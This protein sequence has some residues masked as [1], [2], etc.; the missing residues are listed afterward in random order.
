MYVGVWCV[1]MGMCSGEGYV[2][3]KKMF[4]GMGGAQS[5]MT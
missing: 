3:G 1:G 2:K 5:C 4:V